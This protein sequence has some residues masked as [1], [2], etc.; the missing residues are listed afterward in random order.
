MSIDFENIPLSKEGLRALL[1]EET[2]QMHPELRKQTPAGL[3]I[4]D[5]KAEAAVYKAKQ[6]EYVHTARMRA[7]SEHASNARSMNTHLVYIELT[8][9]AK[10]AGKHVSTNPVDSMDMN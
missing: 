1:W 3:H 10:V 4:P 6:A 9:V 5:V 2:C 7:L 8:R